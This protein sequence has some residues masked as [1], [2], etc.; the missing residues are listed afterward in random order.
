MSGKLT[1]QFIRKVSKGEVMN[2][3]QCSTCGLCSSSLKLAREHKWI[4]NHGKFIIRS[5]EE[6][7]KDCM[8]V[9][10]NTPTF[11]TSS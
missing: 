2:N 5:V 7:A 9:I 6:I 8:K 4:A 1:Q 3:Y 11:Q 10:E